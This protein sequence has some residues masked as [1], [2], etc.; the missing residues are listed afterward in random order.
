MNELLGRLARVRP[1]G[2]LG[3]RGA[4]FLVAP[5]HMST[6]VDCERGLNCTFNLDRRALAQG[7][8]TTGYWEGERLEHIDGWFVFA[9]YFF[10]YSLINNY[11]AL[12][13]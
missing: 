6:C 7:Y 10:F 11:F 4:K 3:V 12:F 9:F 1:H 5:A 8:L 2:R 13:S